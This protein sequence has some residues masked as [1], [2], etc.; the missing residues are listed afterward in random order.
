[1][2]GSAAEPA[3]PTGGSAGGAI[4][5]VV[6]ASGLIVEDLVIGDGPACIDP[7]ANVEVRFKSM[8][9]DG[10]VYD[11][12]EGTRTARYP[13]K[14]LIRG[15]QDGIPGMRVGGKRRLSVPW[16]LGYGD[17]EVPQKQMV[18]PAKSNL[19][20]EIELVGLS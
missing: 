7:N 6:M 8:L 13:L 20:F 19:V 12:T 3:V 1:M 2:A 11:A 9:A 5:R 16:Q 17:R 10:T 14:Q 18:I 4:N 15:W